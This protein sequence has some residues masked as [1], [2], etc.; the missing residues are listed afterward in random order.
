MDHI[1]THCFKMQR[2][3]ANRDKSGAACLSG[4]VGLKE[5][6]GEG[7]AESDHVCLIALADKA[8]K[9]EWIVDYG[10]TS[11]MAFD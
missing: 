7:D 4:Y 11:H 1:Q 6:S 3:G 5:E 2:W 9:R 10:A 8:T